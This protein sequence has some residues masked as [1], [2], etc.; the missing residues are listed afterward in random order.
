M[1]KVY[2]FNLSNLFAAV[3]Q[4]LTC[5]AASMPQAAWKKL[6]K[7]QKVSPSCVGS[8]ST[9]CCVRVWHCNR[10]QLPATADALHGHSR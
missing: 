4:A 3:S 7:E 10:H 5:S 1:T 2:L 6:I 8:D 9:P